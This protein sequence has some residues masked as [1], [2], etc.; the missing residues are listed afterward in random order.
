MA[1]Q[2]LH[3]TDHITVDN[4]LKL[5]LR[6]Q[7]ICNG[8]EPVEHIEY[9][10][11]TDEEERD[12]ELVPLK[13]NPKLDLLEELV[14][15][16]G[17][18]QIVIWCSRTKLLYDAKERLEKAGCVCGVYDGKNKNREKD[19]DNFRDGKLQILFLNQ[20]SGAY[21]LD[22]LKKCNYAIYLCNDFSVEKREQSE[23]RIHRGIVT[24]FK[25][26][27]DLTFKGTC[28]DRVVEALKL[29]KELL[30]TGIT[31]TSLFTLEE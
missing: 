22:R 9:N 31:D 12:V 5:Y 3:C 29:G 23:D 24:E 19:Y 7:D 15:E 25:Y 21:G 16:I 20:G 18:E 26:I 28:E 8:Y 30:S 2:N 13:E 1:L 4:G 27:I 14:E 11:N 6:F 10:E 17:S